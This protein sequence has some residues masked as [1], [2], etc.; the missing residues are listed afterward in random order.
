METNIT[1]TTATP[2]VL[3]S[4]SKRFCSWTSLKPAEHGQGKQY[5]QCVLLC[6]Y[7]Q[8]CSGNIQHVFLFKM[9]FY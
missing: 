2:A 7:G 3:Q 4:G 1:D 8:S 5:Q 9:I 6:V